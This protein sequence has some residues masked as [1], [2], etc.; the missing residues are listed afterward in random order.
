M[1]YTAVYV[2]SWQVGSHRSSITRMYRF[3]VAQGEDVA[4]ALDRL[5]IASSTCFILLGWPQCLGE[6]ASLVVEGLV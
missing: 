2:E 6:S 3:Q 4:K 5:G 1:K